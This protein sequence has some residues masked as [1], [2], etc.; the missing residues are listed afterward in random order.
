MADHT[1]PGNSDASFGSVTALLH[2]DGNG[3]D[4][5]GHT[6][7]DSG[8]VAY[9]AAKF[10]SG[11]NLTAGDS[12]LLTPTGITDFE[13]GTGD[14]TVESWVKTATTLPGAGCALAAMF[15]ASPSGNGWE[16]YITNSGV[17]QWYQYVANTPTTVI[18][19]TGTDL[20]SGT[21]RH[22]AVARVGTTLRMFVDGVV[23]GTV[24]NSANYTS[25]PFN[26]SIGYQH[27]GA[28]R[29]PYRGQI[30][31]FRITKGVG[32]YTAN[33][34]PPTAA[35]D[36]VMVLPQALDGVTQAAT[37]SVGGRSIAAAQ[38]LAGISQSA[39]AAV[40]LR[41]SAGQTLAGVTQAAAA[42][43][44]VKASAA[45]AAAG[46]SQAATATVS[47]GSASISAAQTLS[48]VAQSAAAVHSSSA[49]ATQVLDAVAQAATARVL[50]QASGSQT[51]AGVAQ[52][53][54]LAA[55]DT[56]TAA[57]H[58]DGVTQ[59]AV[60]QLSGL[61]SI[62]AAQVLA[63]VAQ[64]ARVS[65]SYGFE[66]NERTLMVPAENRAHAVTPELRAFTAIPEQRTA[67]IAG[68]QRRIAFT[69]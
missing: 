35:F 44:T 55:I 1:I 27:Q 53:A 57:Q 32:R 6:F 56:A 4:V 49:A 60:A 65:H 28:A 41:V 62:S 24:T 67:A 61:R 25:S 21:W 50:A 68:E 22:L 5:R 54:L 59:V 40:S 30:D 38:T 34:T 10:G 26:L 33:F 51:L 64:L 14:F 2:L 58:L 9:A 43:L 52:T 45:Q 12:G 29:Y 36:D 19:A 46:V 39:T 66:R 3:V 17:P 8:T 16:I 69:D 13:F 11:L 18:N 31:E 20:R 63:G 7:N 48:G 15:D 37:A 47:G 23:V 42:T